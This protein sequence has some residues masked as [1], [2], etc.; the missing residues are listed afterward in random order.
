MPRLEIEF[1]DSA[2]FTTELPIRIDDL[3]YGGHLGNDRVLSIA[4]EARLR[5]LVAHGFGSEL[6]I[7]GAGLIMSD[8]T[9]AY[10]A[11]GRYGMVLKVELAPSSV[12]TRGFDL[13]YRMS[14]VQTGQEIARAKTGM[15]WF[16]YSARKLVS[17]P[18]AFRGVLGGPR[19]TR[20]N[21]PTVDPA[22]AKT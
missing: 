9:V 16:D 17:M 15:L 10:R 8:A 18:E 12:R 1:P 3:N 5:F 2:L 22:P 19:G 20:S 7:A 4:Q 13:L 21:E 11:E 6:D 14:D